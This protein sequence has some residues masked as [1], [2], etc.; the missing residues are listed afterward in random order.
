MSCFGETWGLEFTP[1]EIE[2]AR[3][4]NRLLS[5]ELE[6]SRKCNLE[7]VYCYASS[8]KPLDNELVIEEILDAVDQAADLGAR[9]IVVLGGGEPMVYPHLFRVLDH[10]LGR[11]MAADLFSNATLIDDEI[12]GRLAERRIPVVIKMNSRRPDVQDFL[13]GRPG[14]SLAIMR[15]MAALLRAG[16]PDGDM[17]LG[18]ETIICR[19]NL[20]ELPEIWRWAR[21]RGFTP[22]VEIMTWQGRAQEHPELEVTPDELK[23]LFETIA[24]IDSA[25]F[26][27]KWEVHPPLVGSHC[28]RHEY[29]CTVTANGDVH[30]CPGV[31]VSA[32][33][34]REQSLESIISGS[35]VIRHLRN[36][37]REVKGHCRTCE[38]SYRCYG[39]RGHA[40]N[41]TGDYL[42]ED[43][44]CWLAR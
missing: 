41:V 4:S 15:G 18:V 39:C 28:A 23:D 34:I 24:A 13:A 30:P 40:Y 44:I 12:A 6:L 1:E 11:G 7:C 35:E 29:S 9:K 8:G 21:N 2:E 26:G 37:R 16:Y 10:I 38:L 19:Q 33:N 43:P 42:A 31:A 17:K 32:G 25:E 22:Y 27:S 14:T 36:V 5:M 3:C 20:D